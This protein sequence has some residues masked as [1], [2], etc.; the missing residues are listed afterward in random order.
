MVTDGNRAYG[1]DAQNRLRSVLEPG[2]AD[3][4][5]IY[6]P[7][8]KLLK[9]VDALAIPSAETRLGYQPHRF[10]MIKKYSYWPLVLIVTVY[11]AFG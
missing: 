3:M 6:G 5:L 2:V 10:R 9:E 7:G 11:G 1:Y 8:G 4:T